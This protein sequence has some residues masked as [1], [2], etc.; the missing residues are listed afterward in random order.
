MSEINPKPPA[1]QRDADPGPADPGPADPMAVDQGILDEAWAGLAQMLSAAAASLNE[2]APLNEAALVEAVCR[3]L[4]RRQARR[5]VFLAL[6][7]SLLA[8][9]S[10]A[11][12]VATGTRI[13]RDNTLVA[14]VPSKNGPSKNG[15]SANAPSENAVVARRVK[16]AT[17]ETAPR[18]TWND[19]WEDELEQAQ[20]EVLATKESWRQSADWLAT[21]RQRMNELEAELS[22]PL[23]F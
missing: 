16:S 5:R 23:F 10:L 17:D 2:T 14:I 21:V 12:V 19:D 11:A 20:Q 6:A 8:A 1:T 3:R 22:G 15:P 4:A 18:A 13:A 9:V 7:A